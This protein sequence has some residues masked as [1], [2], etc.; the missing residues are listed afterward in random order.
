MVKGESRVDNAITKV[1]GGKQKRK[2]GCDDGFRVR[3]QQEKGIPEL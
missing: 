2:V 3:Q 1:A